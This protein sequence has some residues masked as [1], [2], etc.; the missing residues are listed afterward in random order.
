MVDLVAEVQAVPPLSAS[1]SAVPTL[2]ATVSAVPTLGANV[3][4]V[5]T[6]NKSVAAVASLVAAV[7][8]VPPIT[9]GLS[10]VP[11][12]TANLE[13]PMDLWANAVAQGARLNRDFKKLAASTD[14]IDV[15]GVAPA[16][17]ELPTG[18]IT[19]PSFTNSGYIEMTMG[20][21]HVPNSETV[22]VVVKVGPGGGTFTTVG[23]FACSAFPANAIV[24]Q[25]EFFL[26]LKNHGPSQANYTA[27]MVWNE[28]TGITK[29]LDF[30][31]RAFGF[32]FQ[33]PATDNGD[34]E[35]RAEISCNGGASFAVRNYF[36]GQFGGRSGAF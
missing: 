15:G 11:K 28:G 6:L 34:M 4:A 27:R 22:T 24:S 35:I 23:T 33:N 14:F 32:N 1:V 13:G 2:G 17:V 8:A 9:A 20:A 5:P 36:I 12:L 7:T 16:T 29:T 30:S 3:Q 26:R 10:A 21:A 25:W 18:L 19:Y 31:N